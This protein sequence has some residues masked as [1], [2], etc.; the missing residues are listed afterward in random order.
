M[1]FSAELKESATRRVSDLDGE[2]CSGMDRSDSIR[3]DRAMTP[4]I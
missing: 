4:H 3:F 2:L 1:K